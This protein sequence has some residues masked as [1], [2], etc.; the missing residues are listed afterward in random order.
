MTVGSPFTTSPDAP[1]APQTSNIEE[2]SSLET[3]N[4]RLWS[5]KWKPLEEIRI[6]SGGPA[7]AEDGTVRLFGSGLI[8]LPEAAVNGSAS[9]F[10]MNLDTQYRLSEVTR[11][12]EI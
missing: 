10:D 3:L 8:A 6:M 2:K 4:S 7:F 1:G 9:E 5:S 12:A 11:P